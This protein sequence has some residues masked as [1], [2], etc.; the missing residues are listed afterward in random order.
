[1]DVSIPADPL[2]DK[3]LPSPVPIAIDTEFVGAHTLTV[4]AAARLNEQTLAVQLYRSGHIPDIPQGF[5]A[6]KYL[7]MTPEKYGRYCQGVILR[8][9]KVL[10][11]DL[12]PARVALDLHGIDQV[13]VR[14]RTQGLSPDGQIDPFSVWEP[15]N[16]RWNTRT[17]R[18]EVPVVS[19]VLVGHFL[20]ADFFRIFG[21]AF[22]DTLRPQGYQK[23]AEVVVRSR[24][25]IAFAER[26][27]KRV[28]GDPTLEYLIAGNYAFAVRVRMRDTMLPYGKG[29]LEAHSQ[30]F[31]G[32]GKSGALAEADKRNMLEAF[33]TRTDEAYG[34]A[35][36]DVVNTL[37]VY[38]AMV[39]MDREISR[40]FDLP[41]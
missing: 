17:G 8:P 4:Q 29:S 9:V 3:A 1:M 20:R 18:L 13:Q 23:R 33:R 26:T 14:T 31:L 6:H 34:Y 19:L 39:A 28:I 25:I 24:K 21:R 27:G 40:A 2:P 7:P 5:D 16:A 36:V 38:E 10:T 22:L 30:T 32:L 15:A 12:S 41:A 37:L 35:M 11:P